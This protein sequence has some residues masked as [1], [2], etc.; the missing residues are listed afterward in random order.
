MVTH[1]SQKKVP[2][3]ARVKK[4]SG[5]TEKGAKKITDDHSPDMVKKVGKKSGSKKSVTTVIQRERIIPLPGTSPFLKDRTKFCGPKHFYSTNIPGSYNHTY[6]CAML[7]DPTLIYAYWEILNSDL[8]SI[9]N[10]IGHESFTGSRTI[11]RV[12]DTTETAHG[13]VALGDAFD[14]NLSPDADDAYISITPGGMYVLEIGLLTREKRFFR[15]AKSNSI[16]SP[17]MDLSLVSDENW[18]M[19]PMDVLMKTSLAGG[20]GSSE[21]SRKLTSVN[22]QTSQQMPL[23]GIQS[24]LMSASGAGMMS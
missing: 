1:T 12:F 11:L 19:V 23:P 17:R 20:L 24:T 16:V 14:V 10:L 2:S 15:I 6:L 21:N 4:Q 13:A 9:R 7:R 22:S 8:K 18:Q 5:T 3:K